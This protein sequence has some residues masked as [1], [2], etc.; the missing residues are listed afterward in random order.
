MAPTF[1]WVRRVFAL[2]MVALLAWVLATGL[3]SVERA[4][5]VS[6]RFGLAIVLGLGGLLAA[7][8]SW[9]TLIDSSFRSGIVTFGATLPIRHLPLGG[10]G[11]LAGLSGVSKAMGASNAHVAR[12]APFFMVATA[13]GASLAASP[14]LWIGEAPTWM[15]LIVS[16]GVAGTVAFVLRG[17]WLVNVVVR[18]WHGVDDI[19]PLN[20]RVAVFWSFVAMS[21]A[22][23]AFSVLFPMV[24]SYLEA[25]AGLSAAWL[26]G[27]LFVIAPAGLGVREAA[28]VALWPE[29][30]TATVVAA[31]LTHRVSTL[32]AEMVLFGLS[33][34]LSKTFLN[35]RKAE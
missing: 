21:G 34:R 25:V 35:P 10:L 4:D 23:A 8:F 31:A 12:A 30:D 27:F 14:I 13:S 9:S 2:L 16:F 11:Q 26:I 18:R 15:R 33:W 5:A 24:G 22:A 28:L 20:L 19:E 32:A 7:S 29:I 1:L 3:D 17:N 6:L